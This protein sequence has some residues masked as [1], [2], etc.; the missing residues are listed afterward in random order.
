MNRND[1][2]EQEPLNNPEKEESAAAPTPEEEAAKAIEEARLTE[3]ERLEAERRQ[4][5]AEWEANFRRAEE[6][7]RREQEEQAEAIRREYEAKEEA[8]KAAKAEK[9]ARKKKGLRLTAAV[10]AVAL[11]VGAAGYA[12][13]EISKTIK[14]LKDQVSSLEDANNRDRLVDG[15]VPEAS[16]GEFPGQNG[17]D[18]E[19]RPE[20]P[21][22]E[23]TEAAAVE[24]TSDSRETV[25]ADPVIGT[26]ASVESRITG[27][28]DVS[29]I[30]EQVLP[31]VVSIVITQTVSYPSYWGGNREYEQTG[32]GSGIIIGDDGNELWIV[33]NHHVIEDADT[34]EITFCDEKS[35]SAYLK[36][37]DKDNDLA[38]VGVKLADMEKSTRDSIKV[39]TIGESDSLKLGQGV[40]A[41]GNALGWGQSVTTGVVSALNRE[42]EFE[43]G[44]KM[45]LLQT[46]AAINPGNSG[47]ALL[48]SKGELVGINN[49]KYSDTDVEGI[50]F[51]IPISSVKEIMN[52]LSL[53]Q[54]RTPV[55]EADYPYLG[56]TFKNLS[57][58]YMDA[59]G[60]PNGAYIYE[61][62]E[63]TP[64][65]KAGLLA[66][67]IIIG[68]ND[69]KISSYD[70]LVNELQYYKGGTEVELTVMRLNRGQ[71][72]EV[73]VTVTLGLRSEYQ[74]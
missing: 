40:I 50:G 45:Y 43:D 48:N 28:T 62:A 23:T 59:Y 15:T 31:S 22:R 71:Y 55:A 73:K 63:G 21:D 9:K 27:L 35:V 68:I 3:A 2:Y 42:V 72:S 53:M 20:R 70:D 36:G 13:G 61:V 65:A 64:A 60:I 38:V 44:T 66:Y 8:E 30:V 32:A 58:G 47:G 4:Q 46:S 69:V 37:S 7:R 5:E 17:K 19:S 24:Q 10:L 25:S 52:K 67:D 26:A 51:A 34:I 11:L 6:E 14:G 41:I 56:V 16:A 54:P 18:R 33:T 29:D 1:E 74:R 57:S 49:S 12:A 39:I